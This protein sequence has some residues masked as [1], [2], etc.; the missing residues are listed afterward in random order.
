MAKT[1]AKKANKAKVSKGAKKSD[2]VIDK[3]FEK[4]LREKFEKLVV[5][6]RDLFCYVVE[7]SD[8]PVKASGIMHH[9]MS[10]LVKAEFDFL[11]GKIPFEK[12]V[13]ES[14]NGKK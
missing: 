6:H 3:D 2:A 5:A 9:I 1:K 10:L 11:E 7:S 4:G 12:E 8:S 14:G 13:E